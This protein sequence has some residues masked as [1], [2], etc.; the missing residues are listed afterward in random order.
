M[1]RLVRAIAATAVF[2]A[3]TTLSGQNAVPFK[4]GTYDGIGTLTNP[5]VA[6]RAPQTR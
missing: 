6:P 3:G 5:I 1:T 4:L 2:V